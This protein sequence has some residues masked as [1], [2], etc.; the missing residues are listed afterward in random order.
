MI[1]AEVGQAHDGSLGMA[2]AYIDALKD[3]GVD[4]IKFQMHIAD[5]ES[6]SAEPF[7]VPFSYEDATRFDYWKRMEFTPIQWKELK[8]HCE[9]ENLEFICSP[10][11]NAAVDVLEV[12]NVDQY[13]I[14]SGEVTNHLLLEKIA[15][16]KK[17]VILSSGMNNWNELEAAIRIFQEKNIPVS[18]LQCTTAYPSLPTQWGLNNISIMKEKYQI[19]IGYSD[20][21]GDIFACMAAA[22]LGANLFEFHVVF[23]QGMFGPDAK[24]SIPIHKVQQLST[25]I[26]SV[27]KAMQHPVDKNDLAAMEVIKSMFEK[28]LAVNQYLPAGTVLQFEHLEAKKPAAMGIAAGRYKEIIGRKLLHEKQQWSFLKVADLNPE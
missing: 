8:A 19:P 26:L 5:A 15:A 23:D 2:H 12:L 27:Q 16:T 6:S 9:A 28:S 11:S 10:F 22:A 17:P 21:S 13:K 20:H 1:I 25:G 3:K 18:L 7:R 14:G 4:A 24:S